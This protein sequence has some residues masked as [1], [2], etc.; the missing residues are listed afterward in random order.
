MSLDHNK[1]N[2]SVISGAHVYLL[3]PDK[4]LVECAEQRILEGYSQDYAKTQI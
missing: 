3:R 2:S 1:Q 4:D